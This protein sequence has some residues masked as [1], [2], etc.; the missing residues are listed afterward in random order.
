MG[1]YRA[2]ISTRARRL[3]GQL[4]SSDWLASHLKSIYVNRVS[5]RLAGLVHSK[6]LLSENT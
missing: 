3:R 1:K 5:A 6:T 2:L 4:I